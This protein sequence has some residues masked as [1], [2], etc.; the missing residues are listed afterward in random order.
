VKQLSVPSTISD[1]VAAS[2]DEFPWA[3]VSF[4]AV[5]LAAAATGGVVVM[6]Q[7]RTGLLS[8]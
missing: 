3:T 2:P 8:A 6:R 1:D 7:R 5:G 4:A